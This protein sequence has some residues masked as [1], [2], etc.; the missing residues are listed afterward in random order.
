VLDYRKSDQIVTRPFLFN[1]KF[2][3]ASPTGVHRVAAELISGLD[4]LVT[5]QPR[6]Q[7]KSAR[8]ITPR[9]ARQMHLKTI[10]QSS[11]GLFTWQ[12]WEQIDLPVLARKSLLINLCNLAPLMAP[13]CI[14][15]IHDAQVFL[16]PE[17]YT[18]AFRSFYQFM[19]PR[20][21]SA[22]AAILTVSEYSKKELVR[23]GVA[24]EDKIKVIHNGGDHILACEAETSIVAKLGLDPYKYVV[25]LANTQAHKNISIL[26]SAFSQDT[27]EKVRLVLIGKASKKEFESAGLVPPANTV[28]AGAVT[29][30]QFR[31][32]MEQA[33]AL[34]FPSTT[35]GFGLPPLEAMYVGCPVVAAPCGALPEVC[36]N[37]AAYVAPDDA[38]GWAAAL[39][40]LIEDERLRRTAIDLGVKQAK[41]FTWVA[42]ARKLQNIIEVVSKT[43]DL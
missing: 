24:S 9:N 10:Q 25:A 35:E 20:I 2:L 33:A 26:F 17:S 19:L 40:K 3:T 30:G 7:W 22:S 32:L 23:F 38:L 8:L 11:S 13:A 18:P 43:I 14:T 37:A 31:A 6:E 28:F 36:G 34:A 41:N 15:M 16:T 27:M 1:G 4:K 21:G 39:L 29:D 5:E 12:P 42:S